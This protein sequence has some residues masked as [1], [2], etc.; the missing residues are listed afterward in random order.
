MIC[1]RRK[2][3][4]K[5]AQCN[6]PLEPGETK[7]SYCGLDVNEGEELRKREAASRKLNRPS[8]AYAARNGLQTTSIVFLIITCA[9]C[10]LY[11]VI[12]II[13]MPFMPKNVIGILILYDILFWVQ[14][15]IEIPFTVYYTRTVNSGNDV[16]LAFKICCLLFANRIAGI[17]MLCDGHKS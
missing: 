3:M 9:L 10:G 5:C 1:Y 7:C 2:N 8:G 15:I 17:L 11:A 16:S 13:L 6:T 14:F 4:K 12:A